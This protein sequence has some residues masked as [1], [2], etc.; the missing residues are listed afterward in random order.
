LESGGLVSQPYN[1][2]TVVEKTPN[3]LLQR[4]LSPYKAFSDLD[5]KTLAENDAESILQRL[6]ALDEANRR[7]LSIRFRQVHALANSRGT[8][9][10]IAASGDHGRSF[11]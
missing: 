5:W 9:I 7:H 10:L 11:I 6:P 1:P 2:R 8:A 4:F 3:I